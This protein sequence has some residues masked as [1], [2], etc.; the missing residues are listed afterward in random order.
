MQ[1]MRAMTHS[2]VRVAALPCYRADTLP[3]RVLPRAIL[4]DVLDIWVLRH[5]AA[6]QVQRPRLLTEVLADTIPS[7]RD[8]FEGARPLPGATADLSQA[9]EIGAT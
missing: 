7:N 9:A 1:T 5:P 3:V 4:R 2:G 6:R 8:L